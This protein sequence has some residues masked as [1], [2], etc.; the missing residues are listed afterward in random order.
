MRVRYND[1]KLSR[2]EN[3][4]LKIY[5][6]FDSRALSTE[7][8]RLVS[9]YGHKVLH[10]TIQKL[11]EKGYLEKATSMVVN[12]YRSDKGKLREALE[13]ME[14]ENVVSDFDIL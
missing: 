8:L 11:M 13:D 9:G 1:T 4:V 3:K 12:F 14:E 10:K 7:T 5:D 2:R 6:L